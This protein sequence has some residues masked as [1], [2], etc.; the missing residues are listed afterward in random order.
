MAPLTLFSAFGTIYRRGAR[1]RFTSYAR[2]W[3]RG[4]NSNFVDFD[5]WSGGDPRFTDLQ[6]GESDA[7]L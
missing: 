5:N 2:K 6:S 3:S 1:I 7:V 4:S